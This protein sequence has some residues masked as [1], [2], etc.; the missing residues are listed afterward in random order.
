MQEE[1]P[2]TENYPI[3]LD[4]KEYEEWLRYNYDCDV[5]AEMKAGSGLFYSSDLIHRD[6]RHSDPGAPERAIVFITFAES[7]KGQ[8]DKRVFPIGQVHP[9]K[10]DR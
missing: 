8:D 10:Y 6:G 1:Y 4:D 3:R 7:R 2:D 5:T 9:L